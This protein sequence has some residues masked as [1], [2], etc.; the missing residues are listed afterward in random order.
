MNDLRPDAEWLRWDGAR[1]SWRVTTNGA[2]VPATELRLDG[3]A[4]QRYPAGTAAS[5]DVV[6]DFPYSPTGRAV[7]TFSLH[8]MGEAQSEL[9]PNWRV[10]R[11]EP[12]Q[13]GS[14][15]R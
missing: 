3:I 9:L 11:G 14:D 6:C 7:S 12:A 15:L 8:T 10:R 4:F 13:P 2:D 5:Q 1:L